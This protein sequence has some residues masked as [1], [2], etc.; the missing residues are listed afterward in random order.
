[1][2][3]QDVTDVARIRLALKSPDGC[4]DV[5]PKRH[6][7]VTAVNLAMRSAS[8]NV[9]G[10]PCVPKRRRVAR[11]SEGRHDQARF[12]RGSP[13][14][15][16]DKLDRARDGMCPARTASPTVRTRIQHES[17]RFQTEVHLGTLCGRSR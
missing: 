15:R 9:S 4:G 8:E 5:F 7:V 16:P 1:M 11:S 12:G 6:T 10:Q 13:P 3:I 14:A 17:R 2:R